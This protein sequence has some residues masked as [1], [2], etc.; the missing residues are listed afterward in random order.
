MTPGAALRRLLSPAPLA[1]VLLLAVAVL[2]NL[3]LLIGSASPFYRDLGTT[4]RPARALFSSLGASAINPH[5][6]FG[7]P[8]WG[9]PNLVLAYPFP[10]SPRFL[11]LHLLLHLALGTVGAFLFLRR[12]VRASE[13]ALLGAAAFGLSGYVLSSTAFLNATTTIAWAP[14]LLFF[15]AA[16]RESSGRSLVRCGFGAT[17]TAAL[18]VLGGEPALAGLSLL[19]ALLFAAA[20]P[21]EVRR[22]TFLAAGG[23]SLAA[24]LLLSP[25]LFAAWKAST[26]SSRRVR[27]FSFSEFAAVGFHPLRLLETPF[28]LF[29]GDPSRLVSGGFW[30]FAITQ[31]NPPYLAS[32]G[33]GVLPL[34]LALLFVVSA[35][36]NEGRF[37]IGAA[38][39]SLLAALAP[40]L[41]GAPAVYAALPALHLIR[42]P[43]KAIFV[44]TLSIAVLAA[45]ATD[46][47]LIAGSLPRF[48]AR[49]ALVLGG[50]A[51]LFAGA[52]LALRL[53]PDLGR[54][55]LT[56][57]WDPSW[58]SSPDA[59]LEPVLRR[60][61]VQAALTAAA[62]L[63][64]AILVRR[65]AED[66]R[67]RLFLLI[68]VG[69][70]LLLPAGRLLPR[71]PSA[72]FEPVYP[73]VARAAAIPGRV[74]ERAPKDL[75]PVRRGLLGVAFADDLTDV[76]RAQ[77]R[78]GWAL[79]GASKGLR[80]AYDQDPD[81]SY[82]YLDRMTQGVLSVRDWRGKLKW[83][84]SAGVGSVIAGDVPPETP[85]LAPVFTDGEA[86]IPATLFRLTDPL[87]GIR[88][89]PR[90]LAADSV[91]RTVVL[92]ED[93]SFDPR[94]AVVVAGREAASLAAPRE[95]P[96]ARARIVADTPEILVVETSGGVPAVLHVDRT[97][98]P[99]VRATVN[100]RPV[101]PLVANLHLVG[102]PVPAG[103]SHVVVELAP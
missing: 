82:S 11:G 17:V 5:A 39:L 55:L 59:V 70:E 91:T 50:F 65:T 80:Y 19:V 68:A 9:N 53:S 15:V 73:L 37:W 8:Y 26:F 93:S 83:L 42:Y 46:R 7:Q 75:D 10:R 40:W 28:P 63:L 98:T 23:G 38:G 34:S 16:A 90:V 66:P 31:G 48:R 57:L 74:F 2:P 35:K 44:L 64:L 52:S 92:F 33:F 56:R 88:R 81:G 14:W 47:L 36:R 72:W 4:Q 6:S 58:A 71:I 84:R 78:Q 27:G 41:P 51:S 30:G 96:L 85:G 67:A 102:I 18:L 100:Q 87:P 61:P 49:A 95:D 62:L 45:L 12:L 1:A 24:T 22:G 94:V 69:A 103:T 76:A 54:G 13:A 77:L 32:L 43:V 99:L 3:D 89:C 21:R 86:G 25:W 29:L 20:S 79:G 97:Y 60:L 101:V